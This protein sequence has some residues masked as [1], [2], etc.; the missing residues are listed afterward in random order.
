MDGMEMTRSIKENFSTSHI[1]IILLTAKSGIE[2][3]IAGVE[4][5]ADAYIVK[6]FNATYLKA[7]TS[8]LIEQ[9]RQ[10]I[11]KF[12]DNKTIDPSTH[13]EKNS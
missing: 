12:R 8:N 5:G 1:P 10:V 4:Q 7:V 13:V 2:D 11:A 9:R 3:Q 6:P